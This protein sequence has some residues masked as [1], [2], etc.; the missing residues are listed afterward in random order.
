MAIRVQGYQSQ[1]NLTGR[2]QQRVSVPGATPEAFGSAIGTSLQGLAGGIKSLADGIEYQKK[3]KGEADAR[4]GV[5]ELIQFDRQL[6]SD[7]NTGYLN[8]TGSRALGPSRE[9]TEAALKSKRDE[10]AARLSPEA[11]RAF[12][13][14]AMG[15]MNSSLDSTIR[16]ESD[17]LRQYTIGSFDAAVNTAL[18]TA[19]RGSGDPNKFQA[20]LDT[21][22]KEAM[23]A[24][25]LVGL[26]D[27]ERAQKAKELTSAAHS[28][29]VVAFARE[30]PVAAFAYLQANEGNIDIDTYNK[31]HGALE[32]AYYGAQAMNWVANNNVSG[33]QGFTPAP[34]SSIPL[35]NHS[36]AIEYG[37]GA[38]GALQ[39]HAQWSGGVGAAV[40]T[41]LGPNARIYVSSGHR[42]QETTSQ[43]GGRGAGDV[44]IYD[45]NGKQLQWDDPRALQIG[46]VLAS[47][48]Y[49]GFGAGPSYMNGNM[50][51]FDLGEGGVNDNGVTIGARGGVTVWSDDDGTASDNGP[52]AAQWSAQLQAA[53]QAGTA[54][55]LPIAPGIEMP[56]GGPPN[57]LERLGIP[58]FI[59]GPESLGDPSAVNGMGSGAAGI[60]Q[61][62]PKTY[63][64]L[65]N[66]LK[67][68]WA[69]GL[70]EDEILATRFDLVKVAEIYRVFR[71]ENAADLRNAGYPV[72]PQ[73]EYIAHHFGSTGA[74]A[75]LSLAGGGRGSESLAAALVSKGIPADKWIA[76]N[77]WMQGQTV[78]GAMSWF[79]NKVAAFGGGGTVSPAIAMEQALNISDPKL[80]A[81]VLEELRLRASVEEVAGAAR[82]QGL[83]DQAW[84]IIDTGGSPTDI[85]LWL[86]MEVG[87]AG[88]NT[89]FDAYGRNQEGVDFTNEGRYLELFDM[90]MSTDRAVQ[91]AFMKLDLNSDRVNLSQ[92]DL[93]QM[94]G[95]QVDMRTSRDEASAAG[96]ASVALYEDSDFRGAHTDLEKQYAAAVG[97]TSTERMTE[98]Q[99]RQLADLQLRMRQAMGNF[100]DENNRK[101]SFEERTS[102]AA[103][104][105]A[106]VVIEGVSGGLF[107][108]PANML[109]EV[110]SLARD[111]QSYELQLERA[112]VPP[113][114]E[115]EIVD[116]LTG[117]LGRKPTADE[118]V[119]QY[120]S[121]LLLSLGYNP[122][123][124]YKDLDRQTRNTLREQYPDAGPEE[125]AE[126]FRYMTLAAANRDMVK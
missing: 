1:V 99:R 91:D 112:N 25:D 58:A 118:I 98:F 54:F 115:R 52:G 93:R 72:S 45:G 89:I 86:Q 49:K 96:P 68:A 42:G 63:M 39:P 109:F 95:L 26:S 119:E 122:A 50:F 73:T 47:M 105:M 70:S 101:M 3:V 60:V 32:G 75:L 9:Q 113:E 2:N 17:Q 27:P 83:A 90:S 84:S 120:E 77:P 100:A 35:Y 82:Q 19:I 125:L 48:G 110:D 69:Q 61:M 41:V 30:D 87:T 80:R 24:A 56:A 67:P 102:F 6:M 43:H 107:G 74:I 85:P 92:A 57:Q 94:K 40:E 34:Y 12:E 20:G 51:H 126:I 7:P 31:L 11:R 114:I 79:Q 13:I 4:Y 111:G 108:G 21:A 103:Q 10:I 76:Q 55:R 29:R 46:L 14:A 22:L 71:A 66:R 117:A 124:E 37:G 53:A 18:E 36:V 16:H 38:A 65:V 104:L 5:D 123:F 15:V 64:G 28:G 33:T 78:N 62:M 106:P 97:A 23:A 44:A 8:Q 121:E 116:A 88:M 59:A 81:A